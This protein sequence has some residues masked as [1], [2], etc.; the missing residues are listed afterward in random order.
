MFALR[1]LCP[2]VGRITKLRLGNPLEAEIYVA[3]EASATPQR[4]Y[5]P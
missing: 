2:A 5:A 3:G 4:G 1:T